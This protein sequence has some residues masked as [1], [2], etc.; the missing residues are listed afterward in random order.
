MRDKPR[1]VVDDLTAALGAST[2]RTDFNSTPVGTSGP[3]LEKSRWH[4]QWKA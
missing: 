3:P 4:D 2:V 1:Y